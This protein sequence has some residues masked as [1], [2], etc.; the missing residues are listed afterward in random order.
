MRHEVR[1]AI[2]SRWNITAPGIFSGTLAMLT[3]VHGYRTFLPDSG[4][5]ATFATGY[6]AYAMVMAGI[7]ASIS[8]TVDLGLDRVRYLISLPV[9]PGMIA[10]SKLCGAAVTAVIVST[11]MLLIGNPLVLHLSLADALI[12]FSALVCQALS[13]V[14]L[15]CCLSR[16]VK[17]IT[18]LGLIGS[19]ASGVLQYLSSVY[20]PSSVFPPWMRPIIY[21]NPLTHA[22]NVVRSLVTG[23]P[24][25][26]EM[27]SLAIASVVFVGLGSYSL[28]EAVKRKLI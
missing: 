13:V 10:M 27:L 20:F 7:A 28:S 26:T 12:A 23:S 9:T 2:L 1:A 16:L 17:D 14:G 25:G 22:V 11:V 18:K 15:V 24:M 5:E 6:V 21:L 8:A 19:L 3:M 4:Y